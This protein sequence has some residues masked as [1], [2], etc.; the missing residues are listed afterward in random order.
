M[1]VWTALTPA[2]SPEERVKP[3]RAAMVAVTSWPAPRFRFLLPQPQENW[4]RTDGQ[5]P[6]NNSPS[7][8]RRGPG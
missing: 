2:L 5:K 7:P 3:A 1:V 8:R 6:D 4:N